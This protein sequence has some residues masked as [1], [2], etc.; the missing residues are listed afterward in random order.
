MNLLNP[1]MCRRCDG[2][3]TVHI[4]RGYRFETCLSC[5]RR[6]RKPLRAV[7]MEQVA[8]LGVALLMIAVFFTLYCVW[9]AFRP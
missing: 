5:D 7:I 2:R 1:R 3:L 8:N 4:R 9:G 6:T